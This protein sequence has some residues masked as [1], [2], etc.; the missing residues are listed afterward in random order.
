MDTRR[1][2]DSTFDTADLLPT[3]TKRLSG[4]ILAASRAEETLAAE[5]VRALR[6]HTYPAY[7][8]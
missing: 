6:T 8:S 7:G 5:S 4:M 2:D 3:D 1:N